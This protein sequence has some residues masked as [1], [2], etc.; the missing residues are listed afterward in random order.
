MAMI[1]VKGYEFNAISIRDSYMRRAQKFKNNIITTLRAIG[2][3]EDDVDLELEKVPFK[4]APASVSWYLEGYHLHYSYKAGTKYVEN[5]Y[6][7]SKVIEFE[8]QEIIEGNRT[9]SEFINAFS[10]ENEVEE[11]R[12][13]ARELIGVDSDS[14]DLIEIS[15]KYKKLAKESHPDMPNGDIDKFKALNRAHKILKRELE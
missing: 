6:V 13:A 1:K 9:I 8:V 5:L 10:E 7:V 14:L 2:L 4:R 3:T 12:K 11:E 15:K